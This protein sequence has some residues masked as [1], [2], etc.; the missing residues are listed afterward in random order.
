MAVTV[1]TLSRALLPHWTAI[2]VIFITIMFTFLF[3]DLASGEV[4]VDGL[5]LIVIQSGRMDLSWSFWVVGTSSLLHVEVSS[6]NPS[7]FADLLPVVMIMLCVAVFFFFY[8]CTFLFVPV[9]TWPLA[10]TYIAPLLHHANCFPHLCALVHYNLIIV[11]SLDQPCPL[12]CCMFPYCLI[13]LGAWY[14]RLCI[15]RIFS[16]LG[17]YR[18]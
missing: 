18:L 1:F 17:A 8:V 16:L 6:K 15:Y 9:A 3:W 14:T 4:L 10:P 2:F 5:V 7:F 12:S 11:T 13:I